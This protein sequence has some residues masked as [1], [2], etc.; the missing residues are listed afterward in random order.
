MPLPSPDN[1]PINP[2]SSVSKRTEAEQLAE[3]NRAK[4]ATRSTFDRQPIKTLEEYNYRINVVEKPVVDN[5]IAKGYP[6][7]EVMY[8]WS[9]AS[10]ECHAFPIFSTDSIQDVVNRYSDFFPREISLFMSEL[11]EFNKTL[12]TPTGM[13]DNGTM[14][15]KVKCPLGL[16]RALICLDPDFWHS[17]Q[18]LNRFRRSFSKLVSVGRPK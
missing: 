9:E 13:S 16:Y 17:K 4:K 18:N 8:Y 2:S 1:S 5:M 14:A 15:I 10:L 11:N 6:I 3:F 7:R 12:N